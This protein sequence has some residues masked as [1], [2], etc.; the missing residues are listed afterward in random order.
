M[1]FDSRR[2]DNRLRHETFILNYVDKLLRVSMQ[3]AAG[4]L[5]ASANTLPSLLRELL[6]IMANYCHH[7]QVFPWHL[8]LH[9]KFSD[10]CITRWSYGLHTRPI[11]LHTGV[12]F[13]EEDS[14]ILDCSS[15]SSTPGRSSA[16]RSA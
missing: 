3:D 4:Q 8:Y 11:F 2:S 1:F 12:Q 10:D 15:S 9:L 6:R 7:L 5:A 16:G 14:N 13:G